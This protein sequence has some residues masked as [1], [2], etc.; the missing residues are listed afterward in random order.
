MSDDLAE[1]LERIRDKYGMMH[2]DYDS[3]TKAAAEIYT[4]RD[5]LHAVYLYGSYDGAAKERAARDAAVQAEVA[6]IVAWLRTR[7]R[8]RPD[9]LADMIEC[10]QY[11]KTSAYVPVGDSDGDDGA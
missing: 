2:D 5:S 3:I 4:A 8:E 9:F 10:G 7:W 6:A 11:K 1:R